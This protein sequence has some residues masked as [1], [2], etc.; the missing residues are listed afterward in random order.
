MNFRNVRPYWKI[1]LSGVLILSSFGHFSESHRSI[2]RDRERD[3]EFEGILRK[4][5]CRFL[6]DYR[7]SHSIQKKKKTVRN[8]DDD[9]DDDDDEDAH[10]YSS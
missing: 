7:D 1:F 10:F 8:D 4:T 2:F 5:Y 6:P 9:D 3:G